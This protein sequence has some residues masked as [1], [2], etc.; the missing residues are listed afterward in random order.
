MDWDRVQGNWK[1]LRGKVRERWGKLTD[2]D[3]NLIE[4]KR[5]ELEGRLQRRYG[6]AKDQAQR[7]IV[8]HH[9]GARALTDAGISEEDAHRLHRARSACTRSRSRSGRTC[10]R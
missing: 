10:S 3:L 5:G 9:L 2:D 6:Y 4:G 8:N 1:E 7:E